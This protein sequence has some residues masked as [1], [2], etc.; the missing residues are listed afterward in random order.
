MSSDT[1]FGDH[2]LHVKVAD[3]NYLL[4]PLKLVERGADY[5]LVRFR[6]VEEDTSESDAY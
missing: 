5:D 1:F 6:K 4:M 3:K 2:G